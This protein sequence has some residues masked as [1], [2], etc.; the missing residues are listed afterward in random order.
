MT[1]FSQAIYQVTIKVPKVCDVKTPFA[2]NF[3]RKSVT[4]LLLISASTFCV[5]ATKKGAA[6]PK[7]LIGREIVGNNYPDGWR[8]RSSFFIHA[9]HYLD[10]MTITQNKT[11]AFVLRKVI[12]KRTE[13]TPRR[14]LIIDAVKL[15][16]NPYT[17]TN[18]FVAGC[19][20]QGEQEKPHQIIY[21][22]VSFKKCERY[23]SRV[24]AAWL[25][26]TKTEKITPYS[27]QG[28]RCV[29]TFFNNGP[30][31]PKCP[32]IPAEW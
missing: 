17:S 24:R 13:L 7:E 15:R 1:K 3:V 21:A 5:A 31:G 30:D 25:V 29:D 9:E 12:S 8:A 4:L 27:P 19:K 10:G 22:E 20:H 11:H 16:A 23:S 14:A 26:D 6:D 18:L 28:M 2:T 32:P